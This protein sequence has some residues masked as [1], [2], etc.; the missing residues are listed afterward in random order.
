MHEDIDRVAAGARVLHSACGDGGHLVWHVWGD[1][2]PVL[3]LHGGSG[4]WTHWLRNIEP[5][6]DAGRSVW[7]PDLPG[8]GDSGK[9]PGCDDADDS[10]PWLEQGLR[11]LLGAQAV[12]A[13]GFS[14]GGL[15]AAYWAAAVPQ[16]FGSLLLVGA[17]G[18]SA[19]RRK[20]LPMRAWSELPA[21][22][23]RD[24][25]HRRNLGVLM[26]A[27]PAAIDDAAIALHGANVERDRMRRRRLMLTDALLQLLPRLQCPL[28]GL[29]GEQDALYRERLHTLGPALA[30]APQYRGLSLLPGAGHWVQ[31][32]AAA[33]FN[34]Q[35][36]RWLEAAGT[37]ANL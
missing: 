29:W 35:A 3:L 27:E 25:V 10:A 1:G 16:R 11:Q 12:D 31:Y 9:P 20:P 6:V 36:L 2:A 4:S 28:A 26:I 34:A 24:A 8:M 30:R 19:E 7:A 22:E 18:L 5:L 17:P 14:Y 15:V 21:G 32:E 13:V 37:G 23:R 33:A